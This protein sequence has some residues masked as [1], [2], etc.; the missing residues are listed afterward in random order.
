MKT[1]YV[2]LLLIVSFVS[3]SARYCVA[4]NA[5]TEDE[6]LYVQK[7]QAFVD[8]WLMNA[9]IPSGSLTGV[10]YE[11]G[12]VSLPLASSFTFSSITV[13]V[14]HEPPS[15]AS[16]YI[17]CE[18]AL[19]DADGNESAVEYNFKNTI[20]GASNSSI[21]MKYDLE[22]VAGQRLR[23]TVGVKDYISDLALYWG[24][25]L[26]PSRVSYSGY[27]PF[28]PEFPTSFVLLLLMAGSPVVIA[29]HRRSQQWRAVA[30]A[31]RLHHI[32]EQT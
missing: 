29:L 1:S 31:H 32:S 9:S 12:A 6:T 19:I 15:S 5:Q 14:Y 10:T 23:M 26:H 11:L 25:Q 7:S 22:A 13:T 16:C 17:W 8:F 18:V 30:F 4:V 24:D 3:V 20:I 2:A 21:S 28:I 27:A